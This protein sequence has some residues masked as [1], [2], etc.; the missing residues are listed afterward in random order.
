MKK[1]KKPK[2]KLIAQLCAP[3]NTR[4]LF[5]QVTHTPNKIHLNKTT[6]AF[7]SSLFLVFKSNRLQ[8]VFSLLVSTSRVA[9]SSSSSLWSLLAARLASLVF[10]SLFSSKLF[11]PWFLSSLLSRRSSIS[12][13]SSANRVF[14]AG[15]SLGRILRSPKRIWAKGK[16]KRKWRKRSSGCSGSESELLKETESYLPAASRLEGKKSF[17]TLQ[18]GEN[19][20]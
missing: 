1:K 2:T 14:S 10:P 3:G 9:S 8:L 11:P 17:L 19:K 4:V 16:K 12:S 6:H 18:D 13:I 15:M 7:S 5:H 20:T